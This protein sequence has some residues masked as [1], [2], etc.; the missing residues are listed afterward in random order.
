MRHLLANVVTY[1]LAV[2]LFIGAALFAR[3]R[4]SQYTLTYQG[5]VLAQYEPAPAHEFDW[6]ELGSAS[7]V[8]N[9]RNCHGADGRGWDQ[10]PPLEPA[11]EFSADPAGRNYLIDVHL[12]GLASR[13]WGAPMPPMGHMHDVEIAA[14]MNYMLTA[15]GGV[16][17]EARLFV[18]SDVA[19]RRAERL[20]PAEVNETRPHP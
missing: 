4:Q 13:R 8:R 16:T 6:Q 2:S 20:R 7:Y 1:T 14:V 5:T 11:A 3:M 18:P 9:C 12:Y 19:A 10:Y 15:F 17:D